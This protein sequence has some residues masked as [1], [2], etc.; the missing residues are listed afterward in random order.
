MLEP[1]SL[2]RSDGQ[3]R[4]WLP[5]AGQ[6][7]D[8]DVVAD[9]AAS[10]CFNAGG[11]HCIEPVGRYRCQ[12]ADHLTIAIGAG[13]KPSSHP[14]DSRW[15]HLNPYISDDGDGT[16]GAGR[17]LKSGSK[18]RLASNSGEFLEQRISFARQLKGYSTLIAGNIEPEAEENIFS[19]TVRYVCRLRRS[20]ECL[21]SPQ[22][23]K[24]RLSHCEL[25]AR[26]GNYR[27]PFVV[28]WY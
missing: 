20:P 26:R 28:P 18:S 10:E 21:C 17:T 11:F 27:R 1:Q 8:H 3:R 4:R 19:G 25:K 6:D 12:D 22:R 15:Q 16:A 9:R 24:T 2:G 14:L 5:L 23:L 7:V 13:R